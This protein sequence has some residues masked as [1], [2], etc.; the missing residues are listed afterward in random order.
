[1]L[2]GLFCVSPVSAGL[3]LYVRREIRSL[4]SDDLTSF[5]DASHVLWEYGDSE[6]RQRFGEDFKTNSFLL[7]FHQ[8]LCCPALPCP[9]L[10]FLLPRTDSLVSML[11]FTY[12]CYVCMYVCVW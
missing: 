3:C 4:R 8:V 12:V 1:M 7:G 2:A 6:G 11:F 5:L 10:P 9:A